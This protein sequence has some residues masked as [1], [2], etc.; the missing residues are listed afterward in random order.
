MT[1]QAGGLKVRQFFLLLCA[2]QQ[3]DLLLSRFRCQVQRQNTSTGNCNGAKG[4]RMSI[5][6]QVCSRP[7]LPRRPHGRWGRRAQRAEAIAKRLARRR[8]RRRAEARGPASTSASAMAKVAPACGCVR[9]A[10]A[11]AWLMAVAREPAKAVGGAGS[12]GEGS[13][14]AWLWRSRV[15]PAKAH[16][17]ASTL[18]WSWRDAPRLAPFRRPL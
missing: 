3:Q 8:R 9:S 12:A 11:S 17:P 13:T 16:G 18:A 1:F 2:H 7:A 4:R 6:G 14:S 5:P 15:Q 10:S